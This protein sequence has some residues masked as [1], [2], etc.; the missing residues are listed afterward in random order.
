MKPMP[1]YLF[2]LHESKDKIIYEIGEAEL[3]LNVEVKVKSGGGNG[4]N[5]NVNREE[6]QVVV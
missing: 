1:I 4:G 6:Q 3:R 2:I 5:M